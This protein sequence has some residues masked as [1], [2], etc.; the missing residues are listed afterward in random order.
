VREKKVESEGAAE[1]A[2]LLPGM[3][4]VALWMLV[5]TGI[6]LFGVGAGHFPWVVTVF[7]ALF[8]AGARGLLGRYRWGWAIALTTA[9]LSVCYGCWAGLRFHQLPAAAL[10]VINLVFFLYLVRL[11]VR[12][13]L[14]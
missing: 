14:R 1:D 13:R 12:M 4:V 5:E 3:A 8:A 6:G 9:F 7:C 10:V 11:E 2:A